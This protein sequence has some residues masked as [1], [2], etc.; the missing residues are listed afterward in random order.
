M[1]RIPSHILGMLCGCVIGG[2]VVVAICLPLLARELH[3]IAL[4]LEALSR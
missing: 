3:R 4:A 1:E 2:S